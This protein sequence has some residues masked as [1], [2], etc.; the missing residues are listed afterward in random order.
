MTNKWPTQNPAAMN[1]FYGNPDANRDG[2][3]DL[4]WQ[5]KNLVRITPPYTLYYPVD[6]PHN[7]GKIIKRGTVLKGLRVH[8]KAAESLYRCLVGLKTE[9]SEGDLAKYELDLCG[10]VFNFRLKRGGH[11]LSIH[12]W[13]GAIDLS[14]LINYFGRKYDEAAG[15]MPQRAVKVF[16][17]EGW[18]WG[19]LWSTGDAMHFQAANL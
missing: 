1:E 17:D 14:H 12:S 16:A 10:G 8:H 13:G 3:A 2:A 7:K 9:F 4:I 11:S 15:M 19:G 18:T 5:Q 6:D